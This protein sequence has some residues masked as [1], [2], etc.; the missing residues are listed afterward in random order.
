MSVVGGPAMSDRVPREAAPIKTEFTH[1]FVA[2]FVTLLNVLERHSLDSQG[3]PLALASPASRSSA[4]VGFG[5]RAPHI[6]SG[7]EAS[8]SRP[9]F[10]EMMAVVER[11]RR[12][13]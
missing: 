11:R 5:L 6:D 1:P 8:A 13:R 12:R 10:A 7:R 2:R 9:T 4:E 3:G